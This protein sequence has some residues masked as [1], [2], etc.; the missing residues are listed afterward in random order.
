MTA[1]LTVYRTLV[2]QYTTRLL[3]VPDLDKERP[4]AIPLMR[5]LPLPHL[6]DW[7]KVEVCLINFNKGEDGV[8]CLKFCNILK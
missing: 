3:T 8:G 4:K 7:R 1:P 2:A 6:H 5:P